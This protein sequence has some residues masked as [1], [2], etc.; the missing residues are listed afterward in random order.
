MISKNIFLRINIVFVL[1]VACLYLIPNVLAVSIGSG[2][3]PDITTERFAPK[4]WFCGERV[5]YDDNTEPG[6]VSGG[7]ENLV[8]RFNN[9]AFEGEKVKWNVLVL[10]KNGIGDVR[11]VFVTL[12]S[13]QGTGNDI[14]ANCIL[15]KMLTPETIVPAS[16]NARLSS[17]EI[18][19]F[20]S[21]T[22]AF[23]TCT[24]TAETPE[25]MYGEY[26]ITVEAE[27]FYGLSGSMDENEYWFFNPIIALSINGNIRFENVRP[28][29]SA[30]SKSLTLG[31]DADQGSGVMLDMFISGTDFYDSSSSGAMCP[32]TN[33]LKLSSFRYY[34]A[35]GAYST[36]LD[37]GVGRGTRAKDK[38]GYI[39]IGYGIGFN[40][41][42]KFYDGYEIIQSPKLGAYYP[43][44]LLSPG[45]EMSITFRLDLPEPCDGDF[46]SG[47]IYF[48]GEAI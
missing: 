47:S 36:R 38:E 23:Y 14:E 48:W 16:C 41:P 32:Y 5:V 27:D 1:V 30:Y 2:I 6:R 29:T 44:N 37:L 17:D 24:F 45:S 8:E 11:D 9:Y 10:D 26:W 34:A 3:T 18:K 42:N 4:V 43:A 15:N 31:N 20:A 46:D 35:K 22:A 21:N 13:A 7:G 40:N 19:S 25:S 33:Q 28:G 39:G 12:G